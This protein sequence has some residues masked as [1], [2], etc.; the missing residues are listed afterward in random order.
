[1]PDIRGTHVWLH[2]KMARACLQTE[3]MES[4]MEWGYELLGLEE[5]E[6]IWEHRLDTKV[7]IGSGPNGIAIAF[8]GTAS[9]RNALSDI[10]VRLAFQ[11]LQISSP[12]SDQA[13][14]AACTRQA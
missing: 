1:M 7:L 13:S 8:R 10:K 6:L 2:C 11:A 4:K 3:G 12:L 9:L 5:H 14:L